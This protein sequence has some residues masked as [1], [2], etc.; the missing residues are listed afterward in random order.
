MIPS[1]SCEHFYDC[2]SLQFLHLF[3][4]TI[5]VL[6][7]KHFPLTFMILFSFYGAILRTICSSLLSRCWMLCW[8][9]SLCPSLTSSFIHLL[10]CAESKPREYTSV[11][12]NTYKCSSEDVVN[13]KNVQR[14]ASLWKAPDVLEM[15]NNPTTQTFCNLFIT[16]IGFFQ[17]GIRINLF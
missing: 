9:F 10:G 13:W 6:N 4:F 1:F 11:V 14:N 2:L 5:S 16:L 8:F 17:F 3:L 12:L 15:H 7:M